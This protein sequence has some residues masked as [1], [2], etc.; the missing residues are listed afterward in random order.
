MKFSTKNPAYGRHRFS[1]RV[2]VRIVAQIL[3]NSTFLTLFLHFLALLSLFSSLFYIFPL[4]F[5]DFLGT[6]CFKKLCGTSHMSHVT[7]HLPPVTSHLPPVIN[8]N[9]QRHAPADSP[10]ILSR[11]VLDPK[12]LINHGQNIFVK[13]V[14]TFEPIMQFLCHF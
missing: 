8:A 1:W 5:L 7:C 14:L 9:I 11:L 3:L 13:I 12:T 10:I 2:H 4:T 6:F